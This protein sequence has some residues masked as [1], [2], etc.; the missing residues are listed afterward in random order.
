MR[1][2]VARGRPPSTHLLLLLPRPLASSHMPHPPISLLL[3]SIQ[4]GLSLPSTSSYYLPGVPDDRHH[5]ELS[6]SCHGSRTRALLRST[7]DNP[8]RTPSTHHP[9][10]QDW[11]LHGQEMSVSMARVMSAN[12]GA[13]LRRCRM[14]LAAR[15]V[16]CRPAAT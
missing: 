4:G 6:R 8:P 5:S 7:G 1:C 3:Y 15:P 11:Y 2:V 10:G 12:S 14:L 9:H 13:K 16:C